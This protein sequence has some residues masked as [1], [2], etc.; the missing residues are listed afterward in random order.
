[1][2]KIIIIKLSIFTIGGAV[3]G[4]AYYYFVGCRSGSCPLTSNPFIT[5]V[6]GSLI[7]LVLG[8][9]SRLFRKHIDNKK[10]QAS[11]NKR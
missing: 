10:S 1:M 4:F 7:G 9:D 11:E 8:F 2:K 6:Y 5:T 3:I